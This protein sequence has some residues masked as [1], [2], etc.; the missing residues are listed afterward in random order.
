[1]NIERSTLGIDL[2]SR[3][4]QDNGSAIIRFSAKEPAVWNSVECG[5]VKWPT[6]ELTARAMAKAIEQVVVDRGIAAVSLDGPQGWREPNAPDRKGVGRHCEYESRCQGK[7]GNYGKTFP[8]TQHGWI[9]FCIEVFNEL[10]AG[11]KAIVANDPE[12]LRVEELSDGK[13]WLLECFPTSTWRASQLATLPGKSRVGKNRDLVAAYARSLQQRYGLPDL[14]PWRGTHDDLQ[15]I[16]AALPAAGLL[17]G[18]CKA[19]PKGKSG[20]SAK[21]TDATPEHWVEGLIWDATLP[22]T[23]LAKSVALP[24]VL[25]KDSAASDTANPLLIDDRD[26]GSE[27]L[28]NRGVH[29]FRYLA[30]LVNQ[31]EAVG[32]GYAQLVCCVHGVESF[33]SEANRQYAQ[34][35][36][37]NVLRLAQQ[38]TDENGGP[39]SVTRNGVTIDAAMDAFVWRKKSPHDRPTRAFQFA[40]Y[41]EQEWRHV[42]PDGNRRLL[43]AGECATSEQFTKNVRSK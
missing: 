4:W 18:P 1:M 24:A 6:A 20:W 7:T 35:D 39:I 30:N 33:V 19:E 22:Q 17:G 5:C 11:G 28:L 2:A 23:E 43:N 34:S 25:S 42:F 21:A 16:V 13:F 10:V 27:I 40:S 36:T 32:V 3:S 8:Q 38:I 9:R 12:Q 29:L 31:G 26:D 14:D 37:T 41:S 15:A